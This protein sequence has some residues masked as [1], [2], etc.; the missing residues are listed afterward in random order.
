MFHVEQT[1]VEVAPPHFGAAIHQRVAAGF[2]GDHGQRFAQLPE[3]AHI[4]AIQ[5]RFPAST[6]VA[7]PGPASH[8]FW[9]LLHISLQRRFPLPDQP[10]ANT[11][12]EAAP[13][14]Q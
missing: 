4:L 14:R 11:A 12:P 9:S 3:L 7:Q 13:V 6:R 1:P 8:A 2:E 5:P 10:I